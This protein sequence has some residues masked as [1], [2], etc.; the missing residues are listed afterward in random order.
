MLIGIR[1]SELFIG[2]DNLAKSLYDML[3]VEPLLKNRFYLEDDELI[4]SR[5]RRMSPKDHRVVHED[6]DKV[7]DAGII[8]L[9][10]SVWFF[11]VVI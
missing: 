11:P 10:S 3:Q 8:S 9:E 6:I 7:L 5:D 4:Y 2:S 1:F